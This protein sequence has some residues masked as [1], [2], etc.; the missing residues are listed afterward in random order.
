MHFVKQSR[1]FSEAKITQIFT[2]QWCITVAPTGKPAFLA[3]GNTIHSVMHIPANQSLQYHRLDRDSLNT[4]RSQIGHINVW[5]IDIISMV[6]N[7]MFPCIDQR[8]QEVN[9]TNKPFSGASVITFGDL[10]Q[11]PPV[12]DGFVFQDLSTSTRTT[13]YSAL[14]LNLWQTYFTVYELTTVMGQQDCL[15]YAQLLN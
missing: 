1:D 8:L 15:P 13:D 6:G 3:G 9:N 7:K 14:A 10:F 12:M 2:T 5:L 11:L 4:V